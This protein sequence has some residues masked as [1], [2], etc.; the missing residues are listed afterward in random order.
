[1]IKRGKEIDYNY[2]NYKI[3]KRYSLQNPYFW[4][5]SITFITSLFIRL[6]HIEMPLERDI[7]EYAYAGKLILNGSLP[8]TEV[9]TM[10]MPGIHF[11]FAL[12]LLFGTTIKTIHFAL[13][14]TNIASAILIYKISK[15]LYKERNAGFVSANVFLCLSILPSTQGLQANSEHF[16]V[17]FILLGSFFLVKTLQSHSFIFT[18]LSGF[19]FSASFF[20]KQ[21]AFAFVLF[22]IIT[23]LIYQYHE[24]KAN[25][26]AFI[27]RTIIF[28]FGLLVPVLIIFSLYYFNGNFS[29]FWFFTVTYA[30]EYINYIIIK[31]AIRGLLSSS[32]KIFLSSPLIF[33]ISL[34]GFLTIALNIR[35]SKY[36][37]LL[38]ILLLFSI[39]AILP[40][41]YFRAHYY[42]LLLPVFSLIAGAILQLKYKKT[43]KY[44][45]LILAIS[46]ILNFLQHN[47]FFFRLPSNKA[48]NSMYHYREGFPELLKL[49]NYLKE[50]SHPNEYITILGAE[51]QLLF[52]SGLKSSTGYIYYYPLYEN[53]P[54]AN[55]MTNEM[56]AEIEAKKSEYFVLLWY[57]KNRGQSRLQ[58]TKLIKWYEAYLSSYYDLIGYTNLDGDSKN[59]NVVLI[60]SAIKE[61]NLHEYNVKI[62]R[63]KK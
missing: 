32:G 26:F 24:T 38:L 57:M 58:G 36:Y 30:K 39:V 16:A 31:E 49:G 34:V 19:A 3:S 54:F 56:I 51:P 50:I 13:L 28:I 17:L 2:R 45:P 25:I 14:I 10:K 18:F 63:R 8:Y 12:I 15:I 47:S 46:F 9:Y 5:F 21:H 35:K 60:H 20:I 40:G 53:Q 22:G 6:R 55:Q 48:V 61:S 42:L 27:R 43:N 52:Y 29:R 33:I 59:D 1:M 4:I 7:G 44:I 41:F 11:I 23:F 37:F 62:Y